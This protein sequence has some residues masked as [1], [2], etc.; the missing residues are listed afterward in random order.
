MIGKCRWINWLWCRANMNKHS[1]KRNILHW[2][3]GVTDS[4]KTAVGPH[5]TVLHLISGVLHSNID[6]QSSLAH[7][8]AWAEPLSSSL[9]YVLKKSSPVMK[10]TSWVWV[11]VKLQALLLSLGTILK[12]WSTHQ[13]SWP[14]QGVLE[15]AQKIGYLSGVL[16]TFPLDASSAEFSWHFTQ[17][18]SC[19]APSQMSLIQE[20]P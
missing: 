20:E 15:D 5:R 19:H 9:R 8:W 7:T 2:L 12:F 4:Y 10:D 11:L 16:T 18:Y 3:R 17:T 6:K 13:C 1:K 14:F